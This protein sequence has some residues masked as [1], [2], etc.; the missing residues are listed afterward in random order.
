MTFEAADTNEG[1]DVMVA[2][3]LEDGESELM[4]VD[5]F[6]FVTISHMI[7]IWQI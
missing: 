5:R 4:L 3:E 7:S 1:A 6:P 2:V